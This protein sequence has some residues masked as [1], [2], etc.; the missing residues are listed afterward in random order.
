MSTGRKRGRPKG[1]DIDDY[2]VLLRIA[3]VL[4]ANPRKSRTAAIRQL[5]IRNPSLIRRLRDKY[6]KREAA[7]L[8]EAAANARSKK[9]VEAAS[10]PFASIEQP[11][12][13]NR[14]RKK[15][16]AST[17]GSRAPA[18]MRPV[19]ALLQSEIKG[20]TVTMPAAE[21]T[22]LTARGRRSAVV[23]EVPSEPNM[24]L[25]TGLN[26]ETVVTEFVAEFLRGFGIDQKQINNLPV[27]ALIRE[28]ARTVDHLLPLLVANIAG[29]QRTAAGAA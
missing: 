6:T 16:S 14:S 9:K 10:S 5:G 13:R 3:D 23:A 1:T 8:S 25:S 28:N 21:P 11:I 20:P 4:L 2:Y 22:A 24:A 7:L 18:P 27:M 17:N 12:A 15:R 29:E 26:I 19:V